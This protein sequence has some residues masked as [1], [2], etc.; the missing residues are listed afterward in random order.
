ML[1]QSGESF[2][3]GWAECAVEYRCNLAFFRSEWTFHCFFFITYESSFALWIVESTRLS[4]PVNNWVWIHD[5]QYILPVHVSQHVLFLFS[6]CYFAKLC[7]K[8]SVFVEKLPR[9][10]KYVILCSVSRVACHLFS[11]VWW[12]SLTTLYCRIY[13]LPKSAIK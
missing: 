6:C 7:G 13:R 3:S 11:T 9:G 2:L 5:L 1:H 8:V 12:V 10:K 4:L